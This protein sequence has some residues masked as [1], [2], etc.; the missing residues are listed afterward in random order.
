[1]KETNTKEIKNLTQGNVLSTLLKFAVPVLLAMFLQA[2]YGGVD[3]LVVGQFGTTQDVSGVSTG[4]MLLHTL[5]SLIIGLTMGVTVFV[6]Q[7]IGEGKPDDAGKA[8]GTGI[9]L[10]SILGILVSALTIIFTKQLATLM[11]APKEAFVQTC[12]YI[13]VCG[14]GLIFIVFYNLLGAIFRGIGDSKTPLI[15]VA[16]ACVVNIFADLLFVAVFNLGAFG[17]ALATILAQALSVIISL[18]IIIKKSKTIKL[19]FNFHRKYIKLDSYFIRVELKIGTPIA[20][21]D[22]LVGISFLVIQTVVNSLGLIASAGVGVAEKVCGFIMLIPSAISQ[23]LSAFVAQNIGAGL[24][25]RAKLSLKSGIGIS[26]AMACFI[27]TFSFFRGD[28][29]ASIFSKDL[30]VIA[31]GHMYLKAYAIDTFF[32]SFMFCFV[33]YFNGMGKTFFTMIQGL[34]GGI[35]IRIPMV[36]IMKSLPQTN[37]FLIGL[38]TPI[39]TFCQIIMCFAYYFVIR[40]KEKYIF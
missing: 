27:G 11:H 7:K 15:T 12:H 1:M 39:A 17:A 34:I 22:F 6:G 37:L 13:Q 25:K 36:F 10:F 26:L 21:Q 4:S 9:V 33:G 2:L 19:P 35:A 18:L 14:A 8:I 28:I 38:S 29:L 30:D 23:S 5:T 20:L 16:I 40:K 31:S 24:L 32:T 3:L